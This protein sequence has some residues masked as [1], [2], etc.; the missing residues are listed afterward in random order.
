LLERT[1]SYFGGDVPSSRA[2]NEYKAN[3]FLSLARSNKFVHNCFRK[4]LGTHYFKLLVV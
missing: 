1:L 3:I 4:L 2:I